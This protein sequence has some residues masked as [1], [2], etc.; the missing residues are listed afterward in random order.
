MSYSEYRDITPPEEDYT[1]E[2]TECGEPHLNKGN[3]CSLACASES[4]R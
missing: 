1:K 3:Y 4:M 2:C